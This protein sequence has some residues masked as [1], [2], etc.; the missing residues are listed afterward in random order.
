MRVKSR[1]FFLT[2]SCLLTWNIYAAVEDHSLVK[3]IPGST[4]DRDSSLY[5]E[6][7]AYTFESEED[8][9]QKENEVKGRYW[10]LE[11]QFLDAGGNRDES[12]SVVRILDNFKQAALKGGGEILREDDRNLVFVLR[13]GLGELW[14]HVRAG[15]WK[16]WYQLIIVEEEQFQGDLVFGAGQ[17]DK[18]QL[19]Q[20]PFSG[21]VDSAQAAYAKGNTAETV[22]HLKEAILSIWDEVPLTARDVRLV[23]DPESYVTRAD[24]VYSAGEPIH[25]TCQILGHK[26]ERIAD[27]YRIEISTDFMLADEAGNILGG[28]K[29][30][31]KFD[32]T[33]PI[34]IIDFTLDLTYTLS[35]AKPGTYELQTTLKDLNSSKRTDFET[36]IRI[37]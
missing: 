2:L 15:S 16:G 4:L 11:Y 6:Y 27:T 31:F 29:N 21:L 14:T 30:F 20:S 19:S 34:P 35:G 3:P 32:N 37:Q 1:L 17:T 26:L 8:G 7:D 10:E 28:Q 22:I 33:S 9:T 23:E 12:V 5:S 25:I 36:G 24:N 18:A 13:S